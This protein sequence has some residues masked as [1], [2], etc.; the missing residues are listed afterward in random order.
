VLGLDEQAG[1]SDEVERPEADEAL[2]TFRQ[3]G[4]E[5]RAAGHELL[6]RLTHDLSAAQRRTLDALVRSQ[7]GEEP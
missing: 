4:L 2:A 6:T 5:A 7:R 3:R 1:D